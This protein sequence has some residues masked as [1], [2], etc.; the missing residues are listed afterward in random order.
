VDVL[1]SWD[2][3]PFLA[4]EALEHSGGDVVL[5]G[6]DFTG[7]LFTGAEPG[8]EARLVEVADRT[9]AVAETFKG[10]LFVEADPTAR[11][12]LLLRP[13]RLCK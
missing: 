8:F 7:C 2:S 13:L 12:F 11:G 4:L 1:A 5:V 10:R 3:C 6:A 9:D